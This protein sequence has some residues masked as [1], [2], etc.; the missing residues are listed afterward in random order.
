MRSTSGIT[1]AFCSVLIGALCAGQAAHAQA[2]PSS[3]PSTGA[4]SEDSTNE[5]SVEVGKAVLVDT[6]Q[7]IQRV[8]LGA[9]D[10]ADATTVSPTE[11]MITG[12]GAGATSLIIWDIRGGRQF[13]TVKVRPNTGLNN[14]KLEDVRHELRS[15]LP[16]EPVNVSL[17]N[18][19]VFLRGTVKNLADASRA[20]AIASSI[21]KV[22]NLLN[23]EVPNSDP[24]FLLKV[25]FLS[26]DRQKATQLGINLVDLGLGHVIGVVSANLSGAPLLANSGS[27]SS[28]GTTSGLSGSGGTAL[29]SNEGSI[30]TYLPGLNVGASINALE[31]KS[32]IE[33]LAEPNILAM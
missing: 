22:V 26:V 9:S 4:T 7:P 19:T 28:A 10:V 16:G 11:I 8:A 24:Q 3:A 14:E 13:F 6:A 18:G 29:F 12:A 32:V 1:I 17:S 25:R 5:L 23:V 20:V 21:G 2:A 27:T 30:F 33:S 15:E 31:Q